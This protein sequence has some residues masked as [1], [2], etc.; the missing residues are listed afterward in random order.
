MFKAIYALILLLAVVLGIATDDFRYGVTCSAILLCAG[1]VS[2][3]GF[4]YLSFDDPAHAP[5]IPFALVA[6]MIGAVF[7]LV[8]ELTSMT[9][10]RMV[11]PVLLV[12]WS[13]SQVKLSAIYGVAGAVYGFC[14]NF[15]QGYRVR[16]KREKERG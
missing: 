4:S 3:V 16:R 11:A 1:Y 10:V 6:C 9:L 12:E 7:G 15:D 5:G 2:N 13:G 8:A 14:I